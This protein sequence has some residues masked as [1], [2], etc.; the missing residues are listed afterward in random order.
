IFTPG[1]TTTEMIEFI[2]NNIK[3]N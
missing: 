2:K 1:T 3:D